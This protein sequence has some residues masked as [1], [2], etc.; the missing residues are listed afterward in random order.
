MALSSTKA[1][2]GV[3]TKDLYELFWI[4]RLLT[5]IGFTPNY[6]IDLFCDNNAFID[7][8]HNPIQHD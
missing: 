8:S 2:F 5:K 4:R 3:M 7:M 6:D 1:K